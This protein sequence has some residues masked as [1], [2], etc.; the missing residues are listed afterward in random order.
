MKALSFA[1]IYDA[2]DPN[3]HGVWPP[4][5]I[6]STASNG[7][8]FGAGAGNWYGYDAFTGISIFNITNV[9]G[10]ATMLGPSGEFL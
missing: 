10:G 6:S 3:Q 1:Y 4:V 7:G 9:P 5:L 8:I 2:E